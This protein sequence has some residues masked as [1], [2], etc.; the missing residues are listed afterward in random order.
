MKRVVVTGMGV[1]TPVGNSVEEM[2]QNCLEGNSGVVNLSSLDERHALTKTKI[3]APVKNFDLQEYG[4]DK[5][6]SKRMEKFS[7]FAVAAAIQAFRQSAL[8]V[9]EP[10]R[11][12]VSIGVGIGG[13]EA[14]ALSACKFYEKERKADPLVVPK[15][16]SNMASFWVGKE[17]N[18]RG[19][20]YS[21]VAACASGGQGIINAAMAI[22]S[23]QVDAMI[24]GGAESCLCPLGLGVFDGLTALNSKY[25]D[26]PAS[27]SRP[28]NKDREGFV[29]GEGAGVLM[30]EEYHHAKSR[31]ANILGELIG[32]G[33]N[34]D[35]YDMV[36]P[37]TCGSGAGRCMSAAI[38]HAGISKEDVGFINTHG[39]STPAGDIAET[40]AI[41]SVFD[42]HA[43]DLVA[44]S[45]K[46]IM[47]HTIGAAGGIE[48]VLTLLSLINQTATPTINVD[49]PDPECDLNYSPN[50]PTKL[51]T[52][53]GMSNSFGFG[54]VNTALLFKV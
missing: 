28:F 48:A 37:L 23:G 36:A 30:L 34:S 12:G 10:S 53:C 52:R 13:L 17:L 6:S 32:F 40:R 2:W 25:N 50:R 9:T 41:K 7:K 27:A 44:N 33:T 47:G 54:G 51:D 46:S 3:G 18:L 22:Q 16:I 11:V 14:V 5:K 15:I 29:M 49:N 26:S 42:K 1:V 45:S 4:V 19:P 38:K 39:T 43:Y 20:L 35:C 31:G 24:A 21:P 8:V